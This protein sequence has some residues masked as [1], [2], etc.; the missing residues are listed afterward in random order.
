MKMLISLIR[1]YKLYLPLV[2][3][4]N[5]YYNFFRI[6]RK[7]GKSFLILSKHVVLD[8]CPT[9][10]ITIQQSVLLGW[11]NMRKSKLETALY[12]E[13]K[14]MLIL[15]GRG[16]ELMLIGYGSYIQIG[17]NAILEIGNSFINREVKIMCN[18]HI[19]IGSDCIIAMGTVI[20]DNDGGNHRIES[21]NYVN[22]KPVVIG[23]HVWLCENVMVL[24]GV[25]IG[26]GSIIA[27]G[28]LVTKDV[29]P[30]C[31]AMGVPAKV[32]RKNIEW[33]A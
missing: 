12:M 22:S 23:N 17:K 7:D 14:S 1:K 2:F 27:A 16:G 21:L 28:S 24:K 3:Y 8:L 26:E 5:L 18:N 19:K 13:D 4:K 32:V 31:L 10:K 6:L 33:K 15:G 30:H 9:A 25:T 29:P 11:C 20:R